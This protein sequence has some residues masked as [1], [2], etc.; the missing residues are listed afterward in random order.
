MI[1]PS[2]V[3]TSPTPNPYRG[4]VIV[5]RDDPEHGWMTEMRDENGKVLGEQYFVP[6]MSQPAVLERARTLAAW[7]HVDV[8]VEG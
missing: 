1:G 6:K 2:I 5:V 3:T 7:F 4:H 8:R